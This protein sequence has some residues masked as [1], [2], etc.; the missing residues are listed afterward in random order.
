[1]G[2]GVG[3]AVGAGV[4]EGVGA[5]EGVARSVGTAVGTGVVTGVGAAAG[6]TLAVGTGVGGGDGVTGATVPGGLGVCPADDRGGRTRGSG[7]SDPDRVRSISVTEGGAL[8]DSGVIGTGSG[9]RVAELSGS[10]RIATAGR[11]PGSVETGGSVSTIR[12]TTMETVRPTPI[13][14][15]V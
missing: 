4:G 14:T 9:L 12:A 2:A 13:P 7:P 6:F 8:V 5:G 15:N 3:V 11:Y 1:M 10:S